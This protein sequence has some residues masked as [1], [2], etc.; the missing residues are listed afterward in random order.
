MFTQLQA[1]AWPASGIL[2]ATIVSMNTSEN[3]FMLR[4]VFHMKIKHCHL[5]GSSLQNLFCILV[6]GSLLSSWN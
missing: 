5:F 6:L 3:W 2:I 1:Q 4:M